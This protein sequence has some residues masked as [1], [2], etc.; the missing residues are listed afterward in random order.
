MHESERWEWSRSVVSD[1]SRPHGLQ[2]TRLLHPWDFPSKST[3]V[4]C[5]CLLW[6]DSSLDA[7]YSWWKFDEEEEIYSVSKYLPSKS[8]FISNG[9][10][11]TWWWRDLPDTALSKQS[12][13]TWIVMGQADTERLWMWC[14]KKSTASVCERVLL[15][16]QIFN[17]IMKKHPINSNWG[18]L[19][20]IN[21]LYNLKSVKGHERQKMLKNWPG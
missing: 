4:G 9:K 21:D 1:S 8:L 14:T 16:V 7:K 19:C 10:I 20:K 11:V 13:L 5:H 3:G 12:K 17:L 6:Q 15:R 18:M 2:P